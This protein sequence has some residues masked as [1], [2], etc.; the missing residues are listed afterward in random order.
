MV[1]SPPQ[2]HPGDPSDKQG[3]SPRQY[4]GSAR[5]GGGPP[6]VGPVVV[7]LLQAAPG[8]PQATRSRPTGAGEG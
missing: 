8:K 2:G 7:Y 4:L 1:L 3:S 6:A 5:R